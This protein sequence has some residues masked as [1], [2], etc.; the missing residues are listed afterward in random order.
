MRYISSYYYPKH[1][2]LMLGYLC[3]VKHGEF[4]L[5]G[6]VETAGGSGWRKPGSFSAMER[7][8]RT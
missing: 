3:T 7:S 5:S 8:A 1:D 2:N 6:E 4:R